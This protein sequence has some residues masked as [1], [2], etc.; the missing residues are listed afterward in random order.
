MRPQHCRV[1]S[2]STKIWPWPA[3]LAE[4]QRSET[5]G[6]ERPTRSG[7]L[8]QICKRSYSKTCFARICQPAQLQGVQEKRL[9]VFSSN[10]RRRGCCFPMLSQKMMNVL[11]NGDYPGQPSPS[12]RMKRR[13]GPVPGSEP[14]Q[15]RGATCP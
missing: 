3:T 14:G 10:A 11:E 1:F 6:A 12:S 8:D 15:G 4:V 13:D 2:G 9:S 7:K 5:V